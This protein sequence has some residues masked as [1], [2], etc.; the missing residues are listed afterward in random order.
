MTSA[1]TSAVSSAEP[2]APDR[3]AWESWLFA[4]ISALGALAATLHV[5]P[6]A[7]FPSYDSTAYIFVAD[8]ILGGRIPYL[9]LWENKGL[10]LYAVNIVGRLLTPG[11]YSG[12]WLL[13]VGSVALALWVLL[14]TVRRFASL[15]AT[16]LAGALLVP[17]V[18]ITIVGGNTPEFWTLP[19]CATA[20]AAGWA[21]VANEWRER[22]WLLPVTGFAAGL[23][24]MMKINLLSAWVA[25]FVLV[26]AHVLAKRMTLRD[27]L[28]ALGR[29]AAGFAV[30]VVISMGPI[31]AWGALGAWWDQWFGFGFN[32]TENGFGGERASSVSA[33]GDGITLL[34]FIAVPLLAGLGLAGTR[35]VTRKRPPFDAP[36]L[37]MGGFLVAWILVEV[38]ASSVN[39]LGYLHYYSM[40]LVPCVALVGLLFGEEG[41]SWPA[42][43]LAGL[44]IATGLWWAV[45]EFRARLDRHNGFPP[46]LRTEPAK[47]LAAQRKIIA[48][49][50]ANT[51]PTD[52]VLV[53]GMDPIVFTETGRASA[54][55][56][57]HPLDVLLAPGYQSEAQFA[58][59]MRELEADPPALIVDSARRPRFNKAVPADTPMTELRPRIDDLRV[60]QPTHTQIGLI[61]PYMR[62]LP[63]FV[64][65][66]YRAV[67]STA[68]GVV[69]YRRIGE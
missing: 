29:M 61:Q 25:L 63:E 39:G 67:E 58:E 13:E 3:S 66:R 68:A 31:V 16:L 26:A 37:W 60:S 1:E 56:Y 52:S 62:S 51:E 9:Q 64:A 55:P 42:L 28:D 45:P 17:G 8:G 53:W 49:V 14:R 12:L 59:F 4:A 15:P 35:W 7:L 6:G 10:P 47:R 36:R 50:E 23:A 21:L 2:S 27:A 32:M 22:R 69:Y 43:A 34:R 48:F 11:S 54:G 20:L 65:S 44:V 38:G 46:I 5:Y 19:L 30:A 41:S 24:A 40:W 33:V 57:A 18:A